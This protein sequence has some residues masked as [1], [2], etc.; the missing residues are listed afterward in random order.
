MVIIV[1]TFLIATYHLLNTLI[2]LHQLH[3]AGALKPNASGQVLGTVLAAAIF[4]YL[5]IFVYILVVGRVDK[6]FILLDYVR[7]ALFALWGIFQCSCLFS[8]SLMWADVYIKS[9]KMGKSGGGIAKL[10][11]FINVGVVF[12]GLVIGLSFIG[13]FPILISNLYTVFVMVVVGIAYI[14][15]GK[16]LADM[17]TPKDPS[18][19]GAS[20]AI[21]ASN[22]IRRTSRTIAYFA[23]A[24]IVGLFGSTQSA[25]SGGQGAGVITWIFV[26][27]FVL[28][29]LGMQARIVL[30]IR[31]G[32]RKKLK[33][34]GFKDGLK[35]SWLKA[36]T[37]SASVSVTP[38]TEKA[39]GSGISSAS[40]GP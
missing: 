17:L 4:E 6:D 21:A 16:K 39:E 3:K 26:N 22:E 31:F 23:F 13:L 12:T 5:L 33:K 32:N 29:G 9:V 24:F 7:P 19:A 20:S 27:I 37:K 2:T 10:K 18:A 14:V 35:S 25:V 38:E 40:S 8:I 30:Y 1:F 36:M 15:A 28:S 11:K 34:A